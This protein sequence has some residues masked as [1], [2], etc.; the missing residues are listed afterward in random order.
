MRPEAGAMC[1]GPFFVQIAEM[2][3]ELWA[4]T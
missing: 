2:A 3:E 4:K 1:A